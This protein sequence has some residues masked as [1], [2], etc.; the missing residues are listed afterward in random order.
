MNES[1]PISLNEALNKSDYPENIKD[2]IKLFVLENDK[3]YKN[4]SFLY[5]T[6]CF[7]KNIFVIKFDITVLY[8][9]NDYILTLLIYIPITFPNDLRIYFENNQNFKIHQYYQDNKIIDYTT[10]ELY[11]EQIIAFIPLKKPLTILINALK[12]KF[13]TNFPLFKSNDTSELYGPCSLDLKNSFKIEIK[14]DDLK[15]SNELINMRKKIKDKIFQLLDNK[16]LEIQQTESQL[17]DLKI[18]INSKLENFQKKNSNNELE[19]MNVKLVELISKLEFDIESL[20]YKEYKSPLEKCEEIVRIK[21]EKIFKYKVIEKNL[22]L[23]I[24][25]LKKAYEKNIIPYN[26]CV[27]EIRKVSKELFFVKY[28][29][30]K[31]NKLK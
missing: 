19:E 7:N 31:R 10:A 9:D 16:L 24:S 2:K 30:E 25:Y 21:D 29:I 23:F 28:C 22:D 20:K 18:R 14:E 26:K 13:N 6:K 4:N 3:Y 15:V 1:N 8:K 12:D 17:V 5:L 11:Y 27:E